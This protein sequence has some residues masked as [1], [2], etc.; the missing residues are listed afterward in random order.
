[1]E[2][3]TADRTPGEGAPG[4][5]GA[6][7]Q[8]AFELLASAFEDTRIDSITLAK[9][10]LLEQVLAT[11]RV[12]NTAWAVQSARLAQVAAI[13]EVRFPDRS[14]PSGFR[15]HTVRHA[16]GTH[17][18]EFIG[19]EVGPLL[20]WTS[21]HAVDRISEAV[22]AM[23]RTPR[24]F[25]H[26]GAGEVE[27][28]KL[29]T[30]H[31][32]LGQVVRSRAGDGT[33][34]TLD[35]A[36]QVEAALLGDADPAGTSTE[37]AAVA[38]QAGVALIGRQSVGQLRRRTGRILA[39][40]SPV[41]AGKAAAARR[42]DRVGVFVHP[43][44]EPGLSHLHAILDAATA[45]RVMAAV[46]ELASDLHK[47]TTTG[48]TLAECR[49]DAFADLILD[50]A[51]VTTQLVVQIPV[52]TGTAAGAAAGTA[53]WPAGFAHP[54]N[55]LTGIPDV[56]PGAPPTGPVSSTRLKSQ[57][58]VDTEFNQL[59]KTLYP[60]DPD[61]YADGELDD[62]SHAPPYRQDPPGRPP[63]WLAPP[64]DDAAPDNEQPQPDS[65]PVT[66]RVGDAIIPGVG[67]I[68]ASVVEAMTRSFGMTITRA[69]IDADTG[70]T[71]ETCQTR[72]R[73]S[74]KLAAFVRARDSH[75]RF[76]GCTRP[77]VRCD[78]DHVRAWP[79]GPTA[80]WNLHCLCRYHHRTK[81]AH[82]WTVT[83]TPL[84]V[85]TWTSPTGRTYITTPSD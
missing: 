30:I 64:V 22:D 29:A 83:M 69:L 61:D 68:R 15:E 59:L 16:V 42:R 46:N 73:P 27:P 71:V 37:E 34:V 44:D 24:L 80:A 5:A 20:G 2:D 21:G 32:A 51:T 26:V 47:D 54:I 85:C 45:A 62:D 17:Q 35:M 4:S 28:G 41:S 78:L 43:D 40:I 13:E 48:K 56:P 1:M 12:L 9:E 74:P 84:G 11:Q 52:H 63:P 39:A 79:F 10:D 76:P 49:A 3:A 31:R 18:D 38:E 53:G 77:A 23:T 50:N 14:A 65:A 66:A 8:A 60:P 70:V 82:G 36:R 19:C 72:Y 75:C 81:Q 7:I 25:T 55:G 6:K 67:T 57:A 58:Q 33:P